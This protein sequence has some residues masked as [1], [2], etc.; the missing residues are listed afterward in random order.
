M[1]VPEDEVSLE[2]SIFPKGKSCM[3]N[4]NFNDCIYR[5]RM[6]QQ[7]CSVNGFDKNEKKPCDMAYMLRV[8]IGLELCAVGCIATYL[9]QPMPNLELFTIDLYS[10]DMVI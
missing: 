7:G 1:S 10:N 9:E 5:N 2:H 6:F 3:V 4:K 8:L